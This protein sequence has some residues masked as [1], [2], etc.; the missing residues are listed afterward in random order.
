MTKEGRG[1]RR[2]WK[3]DRAAVTI[4]LNRVAWWTS[5][6]HIATLEMDR[7]NQL[8]CLTCLCFCPSVCVCMS[9]SSLPASLHLLSY[10]YQSISLLDTCIGRDSQLPYSDYSLFICLFVSVCLCLFVS[11]R[12]ISI[13]AI[14]V[15]VSVSPPVCYSLY[16]ATAFTPSISPFL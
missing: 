10:V 6:Y 15:C 7:T 1:D 8:S 12:I 4:S 9:L 11:G 16:T 13:S 5:H 2:R 3:V 14:I